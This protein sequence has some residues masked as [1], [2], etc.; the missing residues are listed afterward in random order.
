MPAERDFVPVILGT[1]LGAYNLARSLHEAFGVRSIALG[2]YAL[3]E[4]AHSRI[5][6]VRVRRDFD[7]EQI[8]VATPR[9]PGP[10]CCS[11]PPSSSTP[12]SC[13]RTAAR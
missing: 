7:D 12:P 3:R 9:A 11:Y 2:R 5:V 8:I 1:G 6:E 13:L 10:R 4:T